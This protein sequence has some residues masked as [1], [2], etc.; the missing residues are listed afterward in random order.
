MV[1]PKLSTRQR[2]LKRAKKISTSN[3]FMETAVISMGY[4]RIL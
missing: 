2:Q 1:Q 4:F 3:M